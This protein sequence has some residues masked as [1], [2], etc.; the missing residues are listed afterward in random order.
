MGFQPV[1]PSLRVLHQGTPPHLVL[2]TQLRT[3]GSRHGPRPT[4]FCTCPGCRGPGTA[5]SGSGPC[6]GYPFSPD[7]PSR[8]SSGSPSLGRL[9]VWDSPHPRPGLFP[10]L[11]VTL[12]SLPTEPS[13]AG[14]PGGGAA[15]SAGPG[16]GLLLGSKVPPAKGHS[17]GPQ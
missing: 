4:G 14:L 8:W 12:P 11:I 17:P 6:P 2:G 15:D 7:M 5:Q 1:R 9:V 3:R 10:S 16:P 13:P